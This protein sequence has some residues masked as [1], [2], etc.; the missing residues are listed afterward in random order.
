M[1][2][3]YWSKKEEADN[4]KSV[5]MSR[6]KK[7]NLLTGYVYS[8]ITWTSNYDDHKNSI[9]VQISVSDPNDRY[10]RFI[11][12]QTDRGT[13]E[14]KDFDYKVPITTTPC[15]YGGVRYW[16]RCPWYKN[17]VYCGRRVGVLY[18]DGDY[19]ACRHCYNL[20][21]ASRN[22]SSFAKPYGSIVS[23][24]DLEEMEASIKRTHYR[25]MM[26]KRYKRYIQKSR[27]AERA[28]FGVVSALNGRLK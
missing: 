16:F 22:L 5:R 1:G 24:P 13:N 15:N 11:Y 17:G 28:M 19:F 27:K 14:K 20:T 18:K 7:W 2:R 21:Y 3:Y 12:T 25:G 4:L 9:S 10:I 23:I 6:L 8:S 26:T